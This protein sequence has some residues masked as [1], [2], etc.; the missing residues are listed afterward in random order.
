M[1]IG[2]TLDERLPLLGVTGV[3]MLAEA[4]SDRLG[5][6]PTLEAFPLTLV[7]GFY[8]GQYRQHMLYFYCQCTAIG[9]RQGCWFVNWNACHDGLPQFLF[10]RV[11]YTKRDTKNIGLSR[12]ASQPET[13][14]LRSGRDT[15]VGLPEDD[16]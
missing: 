10:L 8:V 13:G 4:H 1:Q 9:W 6:R 3:K 14:I 15:P 5:T 12:S 11:F 16:R 7:A 2:K